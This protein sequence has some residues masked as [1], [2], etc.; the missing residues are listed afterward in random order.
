MTAVNE[1]CW[2]CTL[3]VRPA[4]LSTLPSWS[5]HSPP[6]LPRAGRRPARCARPGDTLLVPFACHWPRMTGRLDLLDDQ[7]M[8]V[9]RWKLALRVQYLLNLVQTSV[10]AVR[11]LLLLQ[12]DQL[13]WSTLTRDATIAL[14]RVAAGLAAPSLPERAKGDAEPPPPRPDSL[15]DE[16]LVLASALLQRRF[17]SVARAP[18]P[19]GSFLCGH[20][21]ATQDGNSAVRLPL[22]HLEAQPGDAPAPAPAPA[23]ASAAPSSASSSAAA[24]PTA[25]AARGAR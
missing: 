6:S 2:D 18:P 12:G 21:D 9:S 4:H 19:A 16:A 1:G 15:P 22:V 3:G 10:P 25:M 8:P 13:V 24:R 11:H 17:R 7:A 20:A 23:P 14:H 5:A